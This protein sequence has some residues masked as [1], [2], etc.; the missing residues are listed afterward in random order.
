MEID[1]HIPVFFQTDERRVKQVFI[2]ILSNAV[3]FSKNGTILVKV[4]AIKRKEKY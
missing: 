3:K 2:N 1:K 4:E